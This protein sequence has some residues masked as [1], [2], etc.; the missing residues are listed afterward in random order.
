MPTIGFFRWM[1]AA[2][3]E[4]EASVQDGKG[5]SVARAGKRDRTSGLSG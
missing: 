5:V 1:E 2:T 4:Q 3:K